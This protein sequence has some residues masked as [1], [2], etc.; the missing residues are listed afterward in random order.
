MITISS[1]KAA[2]RGERA[3][4][5]QRPGGFQRIRHY[6]RVGWR[7]RVFRERDVGG[8][9]TCLSRA[10]CA[11]HVAAFDPRR[12]RDVHALRADDPADAAQH[13]SAQ[14]RSQAGRWRSCELKRMNRDG[15]D[16]RDIKKK[17]IEV[18][19]L[20]NFGGPKLEYRRFDN[21]FIK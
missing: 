16:E 2:A 21:R 7:G 15:G 10:L 9:E 5:V 4:V 19:L 12:R 13:Q 20:V 1:Y 8:R 6:V 14:H 11:G 17:E 3:A 18:G